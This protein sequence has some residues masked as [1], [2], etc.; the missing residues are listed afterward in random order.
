MPH[1][2]VGVVIRGPLSFP[3]QYHWLEK[4]GNIRL[5]YQGG[6]CEKNQCIYLAFSS[7]CF[8]KECLIG[9]LKQASWLDCRF[10]FG[11][12]QWWN[13]DGVIYGL[14]LT[15]CKWN[16]C[17]YSILSWC[18]CC[19]ILCFQFISMALWFW[20]VWNIWG[21]DT[22]VQITV[23]LDKIMSFICNFWFIF[24]QSIYTRMYFI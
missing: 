23:T 4:V 10:K 20:Y 11:C 14:T 21:A 2:F 15:Q 22:M 12:V 24:Y 18:C 13:G 17:R 8:R 3:G 9:E 16:L 6:S 5:F 1:V 19:L 7:G